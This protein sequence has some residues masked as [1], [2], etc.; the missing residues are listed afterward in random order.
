MRPLPDPSIFREY[1]IR[2]IVGKTLTQDS[3]HL[4]GKAFGSFLI[5]RGGKKL[6]LCYDGR[7]SSPAL[8]DALI[9]GLN[10]VGVDVENYGL[11]PTPLVYFALKSQNL[12]AGI[13]ITGSHNPPDF[14]GIKM[15]FADAPMF[16]DQIRALYDMIKAQYFE[17]GT[18]TLSTIDIKPAYIDHLAQQFSGTPLKIAWDAGNGAAG[19]VLK[20]LTDQLPGEHILL[21]E[22]VDGNFPNHH[23]DPSVAKNLIDLQ[24]AVQKHSCDLGVA[25]DGDGDRLGVVDRHG[26]IIWGDQLVAL[27]ARDVLTRLPNSQIVL[28]VKCSQSVADLIIKWGGKPVWGAVGHS[29]AKKKML[30]TGAPLG[31]ELS[32]HVYIKEGWSGHDDGLYCAVRLLNV[33]ARLGDLSDLIKDFPKV[34]NTPEIRFEVDETRKFAVIEDIRDNLKDKDDFDVLAI[35]GVRVTTN[36]GWFLI[37]ASNTQAMLTIRAE[38]E[39]ETGLQSVISA[40]KEQLEKVGVTPPTALD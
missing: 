36:H 5:R 40:L 12:D 39:T 35:D 21:Y 38:S 33:I 6:G 17:T 28:D 18:G 7:H 3:A 31:G 29:L 9:D 14:N 16:G 26:T 37:R 2:G 30:E 1:D 27:F 25:F 11:G 19:A 24:K 22:T 13:V 20:D 23:P 34:Y 32:G 4:I 10:S 8:A 15:S